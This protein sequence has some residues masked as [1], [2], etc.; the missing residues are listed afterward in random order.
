MRDPRLRVT[1]VAPVPGAPGAFDVALAADALPAAGVWLES[2]LC[3]GRFS[4]NNFLL[5]R[6]T[7]TLR[8]F[9]GADARG[10]AHAPAPGAETNVTAG[11]FAASLS[12]WSLYDV[13]AGYSSG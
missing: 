3:C 7:A 4:D 9:P 11:Q 5:T 10:W 1:D 8:W 12:V 2:T 13:A 6:P